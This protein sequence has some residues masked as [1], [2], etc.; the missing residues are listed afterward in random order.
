M[1][2][3]FDSSSLEEFVYYRIKRAEET[4]SE[5]DLLAKNG[6][7]SGAINRL[8]YACYYTVTALLIAND[9]NAST[10]NGVRAMFALKYIKSGKMDMSHGK[11]FNEIFEKRHSNDYDD[12]AFCDKET[13]E[14]FRPKSEELIKAIKCELEF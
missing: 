1:K 2:D 4:L 14:Y 12:F 10:H 6:F 5:A 8:Y 11:F 13:F 7:Y 3:Q 9:M